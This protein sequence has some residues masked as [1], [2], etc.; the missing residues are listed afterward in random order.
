MTTYHVW[1]EHSSGQSVSHPCETGVYSDPTDY[2]SAQV[3]ADNEQAA[4]AEGQK[5]L[6]AT[7]DGWEPCSCRRHLQPGSDAWWG[8]VSIIAS[9]APY[10]DY[11]GDEEDSPTTVRY[12]DTYNQSTGERRTM[13]VL[14]S[15]SRGYLLHDKV[16]DPNADSMEP[17]ADDSDQ[18]IA[19]VIR[20]SGFVIA[21]S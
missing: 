11:V 18:S 15:D 8:S 17:I 20:D 9:L 6:A 1:A 19:D 3:D 16:N 5:L 4:A 13:S 12:V 10:P 14:H 7:L 21:A 2:W